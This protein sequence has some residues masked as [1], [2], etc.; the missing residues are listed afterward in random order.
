MEVQKAQ[1]E[2]VNAEM[3]E[4]LQHKDEVLK[5]VSDELKVV[6]N[7]AML[8]EAQRNELKEVSK[9]QKD[10]INQL[11]MVV[12]GLNNSVSIKE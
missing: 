8:V 12:E 5:N 6:T 7:K 11:Q 2:K 3:K 10:K 9:E 4:K 1:V